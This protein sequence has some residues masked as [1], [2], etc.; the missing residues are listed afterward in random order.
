MDNLNLI[1]RL[2]FF[3][4]VTMIAILF[5]IRIIDYCFSLFMNDT[6]CDHSVN[7]MI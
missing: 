7:F 5:I 4:L 2:I 3:C 1:L 6:I